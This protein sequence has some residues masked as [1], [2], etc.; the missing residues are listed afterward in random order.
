MR[1]LVR[2]AN[3]TLA[4][5]SAA[6][7]ER[8]P[9]RLALFPNEVRLQSRNAAHHHMALVLRHKTT[10]TTPI[11]RRTK[12]VLVVRTQQF[13]RSKEGKTTQGGSAGRR[14]SMKYKTT[15]IAMTLLFF[16]AAAFAALSKDAV[17]RL[18]EA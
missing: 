1:S 16:A 7:E 2:T 15:A 9:E 6:A 11:C 14:C 10:A 17:K 13:E 12:E 5:A 18:N 4:D 8:S 3:S